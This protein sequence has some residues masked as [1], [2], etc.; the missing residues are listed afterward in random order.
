M[1][2]NSFQ[3]HHT[4]SFHAIFHAK[5]SIHSKYSCINHSIQAGSSTFDALPIFQSVSENCLNTFLAQAHRVLFFKASHHFISFCAIHLL[6][7]VL[8]SHTGDVSSH[9]TGVLPIISG[10]SVGLVNDLAHLSFISH[11]FT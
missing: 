11:R 7:G 6:T 8:A 1:S 2:L 3:Y 4:F 9:N 5:L 10:N